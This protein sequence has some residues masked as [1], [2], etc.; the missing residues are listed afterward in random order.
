MHLTVDLTSGT[1]CCLQ[2]PGKNS[3]LHSTHYVTICDISVQF[4]LCSNHLPTSHRPGSTTS[5]DDVFI[6]S[7]TGMEHFLWVAV[8]LESLRESGVTTNLKMFVHGPRL[9]RR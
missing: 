3:L 6:Y 7:D 2:G 1:F 4:V 9:K 8:V 5:L